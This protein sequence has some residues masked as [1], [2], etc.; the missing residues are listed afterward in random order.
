M[1]DECGGDSSDCTEDETVLYI[2]WYTD[3]F[4]RNVTYWDVA[5]EPI[6]PQLTQMIWIDTN[7][8]HVQEQQA[9]RFKR[10]EAKAAAALAA[11][12]PSY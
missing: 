9:K 2:D 8:T 6:E 7:V 12:R 11:G 3:D 5:V 10:V 4:G 1:Y